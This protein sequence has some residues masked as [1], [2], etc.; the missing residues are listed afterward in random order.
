MTE[1]EREFMDLALMHVKYLIE[2]PHEVWMT[3]DE[4]EKLKAAYA[5]VV[6]Q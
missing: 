6:D 1:A 3:I 5:G 4:W 2:H